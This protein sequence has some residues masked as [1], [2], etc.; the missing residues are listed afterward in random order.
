ME[1][2][3]MFQYSGLT[4]VDWIVG[5]TMLFTALKLT[6]NINWNWVWVLSPAWVSLLVLI[7]W[8]IIDM[9]LIMR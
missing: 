1:K 8:L 6:N 7:I 4:V 2:V 3:K 5:W 9:I